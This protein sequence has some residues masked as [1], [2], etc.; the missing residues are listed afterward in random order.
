MFKVY[1][2]RQRF[3]LQFDVLLSIQSGGEAYMLRDINLY[4]LLRV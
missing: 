3:C 1:H 4:K 2:H